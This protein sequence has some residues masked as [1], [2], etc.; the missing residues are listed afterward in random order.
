MCTGESLNLQNDMSFFASQ[1][2]FLAKN[3]VREAVLLKSGSGNEVKAIGH[4]TP[5]RNIQQ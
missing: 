1:I 4:G 3:Y 5:N 2:K